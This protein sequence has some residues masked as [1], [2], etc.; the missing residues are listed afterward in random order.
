MTPVRLVVPR[1]EAA[2]TMRIPHRLHHVWVGPAAVPDRWARRWAERHPRWEHR[3]WRE[4][5]IESVLPDALRPA[6][7]YYL[8]EGRWHG[9]ADVARVAILQREGGVYADIDSEPVRA[10]D[11]AP[12]M[13][14]TFFAGLETGTPANPIR[15]TNGVIGSI[16]GHPILATYVELIARAET[17]EPPWSTV[18]GG[19]LTQAVLA[20]RDFP[21]VTILPVR[22]FYPEDKNGVST[23]G[24]DTIYTRQYWAT[25]HRL[26]GHVDESWRKLARRRRREPI[27]PPL[28][29][30]PRAWVRHV[31]PRP[32]RQVMR[33][34]VRTAIRPWRLIV[35]RVDP[36]DVSASKDRT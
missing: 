9:A 15:I 30:H 22:T 25:T 33:G 6:W 20:H 21:G 17:L 32:V 13:L 28:R 36:R 12:F 3:I 4:A 8:A 10:F 24:R 19:F 14:G 18:G 23:P 27:R 26:Y 7:S 11:R 16:A 2:A 35:R 29:Q 5:D 34:I 1:D 31:L